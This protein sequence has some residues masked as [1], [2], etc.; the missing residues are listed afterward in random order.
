MRMSESEAKAT[1]LEWQRGGQRAVEAVSFRTHAR[2]MHVDPEEHL[3]RNALC[4]SLTMA[5]TDPRRFRHKNVKAHRLGIEE[6]TP[7]D[8]EGD[9]Q[10]ED[11]M[12]RQ[13][14]GTCRPTS[15]QHHLVFI[16]QGHD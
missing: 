1:R 15:H 14:V 6:S 7:H 10:G 3:L 2:S 11:N 4:R 9:R 12:V 8:A 13:G 5:E 16:R